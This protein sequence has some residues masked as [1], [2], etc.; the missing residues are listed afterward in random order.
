MGR[1]HVPQDAERDRT[2]SNASLQ[3]QGAN[4]R[5]QT[6][7][8]PEVE[9]RSARGLS[10]EREKRAST[11]EFL[12]QDEFCAP[13]CAGFVTPKVWGASGKRARSRHDCNLYGV[14]RGVP[15][16]GAEWSNCAATRFPWGRR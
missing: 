12:Q 1:G 13:R 5:R 3:A 15:R 2:R 4:V 16:D 9:A 6:I 11:Q 7:R 14:L 10:P 8:P